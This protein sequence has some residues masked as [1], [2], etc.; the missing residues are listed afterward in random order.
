MVQSTELLAAACLDFLGIVLTP[1]NT[2]CNVQ[3]PAMC[4]MMDGKTQSQPEISSAVM[5]PLWFITETSLQQ[6]SA[7]NIIY[8]LH[9]DIYLPT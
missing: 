7:L 5:T 2:N 3:Y 4:G 6:L 1:A 8:F 9:L